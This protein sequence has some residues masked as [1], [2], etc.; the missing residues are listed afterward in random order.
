MDGRNVG[1]VRVA[2]MEGWH[3]PWPRRA[4]RTAVT[5]QSWGMR[6][7][8]IWHQSHCQPHR[9]HIQRQVWHQTKGVMILRVIQLSGASVVGSTLRGQPLQ[10]PVPRRFPQVRK[11]TQAVGRRQVREAQPHHSCAQTSPAQAAP[12]GLGRPPGCPPLPCCPPRLL[13]SR[14]LFSVHF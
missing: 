14:K 12:E 5:L 10:G 8:R 4:N 2:S 6:E 9:G 7:K 11:G 1:E 3:G 13:S